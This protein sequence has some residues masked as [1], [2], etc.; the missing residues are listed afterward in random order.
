MPV[1]T[2]DIVLWGN[3]IG[4]VSWDATRNVGAFQ[5]D[6]NF[7]RSGI[8]VAPLTMPLG[9]TIYRFPDL[10]ANSFKGLPG[11][12]ADA[13]PDKFGNMLIDEWLLRSGRAAVSFSPVERLCYIGVRGMGALEFKPAFESKAR[14]STPV[15]VAHLV[16]L[17]NQA[18]AEKESLKTR[19]GK[20]DSAKLTAMRDILRVGTSAGGA[21]AKAIV[22]WNEATGEVRTGQVKAP[23]GFGYWLIKFDGVTGNKDKELNDPMGFGKLEYAYHLMAKAAGIGMSECRLFEENGRHHFMT[24]R[25]DRGP[26]GQKA[27]MQTLCGIAHYDFNQAGAYSYEQ[28]LDVCERLKLEREERVQLYRRMVFNVLARN[29]DD[30]TKNIAFMMDKSGRWS[31][32]PAYDVSYSYN[33]LGEW[34]SKHQMSINGKRDDFTRDDLHAVAK[35]FRLGSRIAI[36]KVL[37]EVDAAVKKWKKFAKAGGVSEAMAVSVGKAH[38]KLSKL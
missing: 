9:P 18:L 13:L 32:S 7:Q 14:Y 16:E 22:A 15:D 17:A 37:E 6:K 1:E 4:A 2:A 10:A 27:F 36:D 35:R 38:R 29:Q 21:R 30:H 8:E 23:P 12:L 5:Y 19:I 20:A 24:R 25:F 28:A 26:D 3:V 11:M 31:L 33:P 34:T